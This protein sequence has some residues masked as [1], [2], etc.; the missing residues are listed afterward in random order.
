VAAAAD[1]RTVRRWRELEHSLIGSLNGRQ[2]VE[3]ETG[4]LVLVESGGRN[5]LGLRVG[6]KLNA[7]HRSVDFLC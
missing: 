7:S 6:M 4:C 1:G 5:E 2:E 3:S